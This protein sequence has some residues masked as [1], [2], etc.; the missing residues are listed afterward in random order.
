MEDNIISYTDVFEFCEEIQDLM[1]VYKYDTVWKQNGY[2]M[3]SSEI[4]LP[5]EE[6][7]YIDVSEIYSVDEIDGSIFDKAPELKNIYDMGWIGCDSCIGIS[8]EGKKDEVNS[9][10]FFQKLNKFIEN[11]DYI[12][13]EI[14]NNKNIPKDR[15]EMVRKGMDKWLDYV[16]SIMKDSYDIRVATLTYKAKNASD[17]L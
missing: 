12:I 5:F 4:Y 6:T 3:D 2:F 1:K 7:D 11:K 16:L 13:N 15:Q 9:S 17:Y 10:G 8:G 14:I